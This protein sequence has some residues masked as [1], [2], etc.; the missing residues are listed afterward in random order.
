MCKEVSEEVIKNKE[1]SPTNLDS[2][3]WNWNPY[4]WFQINYPA[5]S[6]ADVPNAVL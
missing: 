2:E 6:R 4:N 5:D 3:V 1:P